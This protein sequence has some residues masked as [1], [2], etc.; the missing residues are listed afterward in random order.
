MR[1]K[2]LRTAQ[3]PAAGDDNLRVLQ[4][5]GN[6]MATIMCENTRPQM[7]T[8]RPGVFKKA[9]PDDSRTAEIRSL[10]MATMQ[11][12]PLMPA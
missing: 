2:G 5:D 12:E 6:L 7:G 9:A 8:V 3:A 4:L 1:L 11:S 10:L